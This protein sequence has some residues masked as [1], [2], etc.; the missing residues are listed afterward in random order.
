MNASARREVEN[1]KSRQR[2]YRQKIS[3]QRTEIASLKAAVKVLLEKSDPYDDTMDSTYSDDEDFAEEDSDAQESPSE[4][5]DEGDAPRQAVNDGFIYLCPDPDCGWEVADGVCAGCGCTYTTGPELDYQGVSTD[6]EALSADRVL[7]PRS[8]T[9]LL[10]VPRY[11]ASIPAQY[12][13]RSEEYFQLLARGATRAMSEAFAL[14]YSAHTGITAWADDALFETFSGPGMLD[15]DQWAIRLGRRIALDA[16]D[17]DG[18][19]FMEG[20]LED[21]LFFAVKGRRGEG[22][23]HIEWVTVLTAGRVWVTQPDADT[24]ATREDYD[25]DG[26]STGSSERDALDEDVGLDLDNEE[27]WLGE[28]DW[29][30]LDGAAIPGN[31]HAHPG[32]Y[33]ILDA[34]LEHQHRAEPSGPVLFEDRYDTTEDD[35]DLDEEDD[36]DVYGHAHAVDGVWQPADV[37]EEELEDEDDDV[38]GSDWDSDEELSGDE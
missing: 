22:L 31:P 27:D 5:E 36:E 32:R 2:A 16:G 30:A 17:E 9:P 19:E 8:T 20:L 3:S 37:S 10:D 7:G 13:H 23:R 38:A 4:A 14:E 35:P 18:G 21:A 25:D 28:T 34:L 1:L 6:N 29:A 33:R 15:G 26:G 12:S 24:E 11:L